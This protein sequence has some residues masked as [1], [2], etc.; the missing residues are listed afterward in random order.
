MGI[1]G[2]R[3]AAPWVGMVKSFIS[4]HDALTLKEGTNILQFWRDQAPQ[5]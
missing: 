4:I 5:Y 2:F 3:A 1:G